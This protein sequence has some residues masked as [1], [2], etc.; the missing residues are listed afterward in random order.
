MSLILGL[1]TSC[2]ETAA[3]VVADGVE[4]RSSVVNDMFTRSAC[5]FQNFA[6]LRKIPTAGFKNCAD[7]AHSRRR[8]QFC[9]IDWGRLTSGFWGCS[10]HFVTYASFA[11]YYA[12]FC[13]SPV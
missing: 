8:V 6:A 10:G 5:N 3:S 11:P 1:E 2:D 9:A 7:I 13:K 4:V 12:A